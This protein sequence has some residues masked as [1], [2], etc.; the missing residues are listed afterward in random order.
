LTP[1]D[2]PLN[3]DLLATGSLTLYRLARIRYANLSGVGA[4]LAPGRWNRVGEEAI[5]TSTEVGVPVLERL[6]HTPKNL[7]PSNLALMKIRLS[8]PWVRSEV[9]VGLGESSMLFAQPAGRI[10]IFE[11]ISQA[12]KGLAKAPHGFSVFMAIAVPSVIVP[13]WNVVL[14]PQNPQFWQQVSLENVEPFEFDPRLFPEDAQ[15]ESVEQK[16]A[17]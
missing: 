1:E 16:T 13:V 8:G 15:T 9:P 6:V 17:T 11:T 2:L 10:V 5:Y 4:A 12:R 3:S 14:Y 7:I